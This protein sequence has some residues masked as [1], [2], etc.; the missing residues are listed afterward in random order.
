MRWSWRI[1]RVADID[2]KVH[3]T[4]VLVLALG[5][6]AWSG[7]HGLAGAA[8]GALMMALLFTS[9]TL[10][11]LGHSLVAQRFG[12]PVR[13]IILLPIGGV[14]MM[15][16]RPKRPSHELLIA[17]A[18]PAV[19]VVLGVALSA[20]MLLF[21]GPA[22]FA[23]VGSTN[24]ESMAPSM[25]TLIAWLISGNVMLAVFNMVP[26]FPLD[27]GRVLRAGLAMT[28]PARRATEIAVRVGQ[29]FAVAM[30]LYGLL[31]GNIVLMAIAA[32]IYFG[33]SR[34]GEGERIRELLIRVPAGR[35]ARRPD[36]WLSPADSVERATEV[37]FYTGQ[38]ELPVV[39]GQRIVGIVDMNRHHAAALG[40]PDGA[41]GYVAQIM[42]RQVAAIDGRQSLAEVEQLMSRGARAVGVYDG[43]TL[44]GLLT[45]SDLGRVAQY[46]D[47]AERASSRVSNSYRPRPTG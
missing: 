9:V 33:A 29:V 27:G 13:E 2:I 12:V 36:V 4:F 45:Q 28:M 38:V 39:Q 21:Y 10:H 22:G 19:N 31:V 18:G 14:A 26:A 6:F 16:G 1:A 32:F 43:D 35:V 15:S 17:L 41:P 5:A 24:V 8:F 25:N 7:A 34:E 40:Q 46:L 47:R 44:I 20:I 37:A 30:G 11:E 42:D 23:A 3:A